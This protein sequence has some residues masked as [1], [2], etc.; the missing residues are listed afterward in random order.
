MQNASKH[1]FVV[2]GL[3]DNRVHLD[4]PGPAVLGSGAIVQAR[5]L[6]GGYLIYGQSRGMLRAIAF[7]WKSLAV[8]G[9]AVPILDSLEQAANGGGIYFAVSATGSLVYA[10]SGDRDQLVW[11]DRNGAATPIG[12]DREAFRAPRISPN[13][14]QIAV[15]VNDE[16]RRSDIWI[17]DAERGSKHRLTTARH[18]L[19]PVWSM[20]GQHVTFAAYPAG[21][22]EARADGSGAPQVLLA[23]NRTRYPSS[24]TPDGRNLCFNSI[25]RRG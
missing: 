5:Y 17:Y 22:L 3:Q 2:G 12:S 25:A 23:D 24:W 21:L 18:N 13:G 15:A 8:A 1:Q 16:T 14:K 7:D 19:E 4:F 9:S 11:V 10:T 6:P 20:D